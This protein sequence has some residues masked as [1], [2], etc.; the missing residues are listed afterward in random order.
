[1]LS[2]TQKSEA[3]FKPRIWILIC[4]CILAGLLWGANWYLLTRFVGSE[5]GRGQ[6]GDM[7]G[8]VNALF[9]AFAFAG[10]IYTV[11]LQRNQLALQQ[12]QNVE[13]GKT[14]EQL[15]Q[16]QID[17]QKILFESEKAFQED[18]RKKQIEHEL[19]LEQ[20]RQDFEAILEQ[21]GKDREQAREDS[22]K[23]NVLRAIR[24]ELEVIHE[25]YDKGIGSRLANL[26]PDEVFMFRL[27]LTEDWFTV[28]TANA[29]HLGRLDGEISR[30]IVSI[31]LL[32]KKLVEE[33]RINNEYLTRLENVDLKM[34]LEGKTV[35][36]EETKKQILGFMKFETQQI[37]DVD[38]AL[39]AAVANFLTNLDQ[40]GIK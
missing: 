6:F 29:V 25:I 27:G 31:Y 3:L 40:L 30:Q 20:L 21:R 19:K 17:A 28:F 1:M 23:R 11:L 39:K 26:K 18:Q 14:Q 22:F 37:K 15:V 8:A 13:S 7:F 4:F 33:Y 5:A 9:T 12:Q 38:K 35:L 10:L 2:E 24:C 36:F 32:M 16:R 34:N